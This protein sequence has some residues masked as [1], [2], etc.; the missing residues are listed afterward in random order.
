M[1][2]PNHILFFNSFVLS[3]E[4]TTSQ[5]ETLVPHK[6]VQIYLCC[7]FYRLQLL[8]SKSSLEITFRGLTFS[9]T[10]NQKN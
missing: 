10:T 4:Y 5:Y 1:G 9:I 6:Y 2:E 3:T 7:N 8:D